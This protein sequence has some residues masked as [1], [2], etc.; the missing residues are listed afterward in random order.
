MSNAFKIIDYVNSNR[1]EIVRLLI[2]LHSTYFLE[3]AT[4]K[5]RELREEKSLVNTYQSYLE[6]I[7]KKESWKI[8]LAKTR[9]NQLGGFIIGSITEDKDLV[10]GKI[11]RIEDWFVE[12][13]YRKAEIGTKLYAHLEKW[14]K[15][16][17]CQQVHS[18]TFHGNNPSISAHRKV[19][20][21]VSGISFGK[22]L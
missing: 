7:E 11:G 20:F 13:Q 4:E 5:I 10:L 12:P 2:G 19:G 8:L 18:E 3:N 1:P 6:S 15:D 9:S 14:F 16:K 21:F 17:G 22:K